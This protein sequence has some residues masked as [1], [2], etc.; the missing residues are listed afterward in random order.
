[1]AVHFHQ[2]I[3]DLTDERRPGSHTGDRGSIGG[4]G[5]Q[6]GQGVNTGFL[7]IKGKKPAFDQG[8]QTAPDR[9]AWYLREI[10]SW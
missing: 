2:A 10:V 6:V 4:V 8:A 9:G 1:M 7:Q 3:Q 5:F